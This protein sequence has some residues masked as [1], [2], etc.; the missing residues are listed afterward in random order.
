MKLGLATVEGK[1]AAKAYS[2][3]KRRLTQSKNE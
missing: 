3:I 2:I 1:S